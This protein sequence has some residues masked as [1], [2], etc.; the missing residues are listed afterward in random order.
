[1]KVAVVGGGLAGLCAAWRARELGTD[2]VLF[3]ASARLGGQVMTERVADCVLEHGAEGFVARST[4]VHAVCRLLGL[5]PE[6]ISQAKSRSLVYDGNSFREL[7]PGEAARRLGIQARTHWG[8]GLQSL[9]RGMGSLVESLADAIGEK[10]IRLSA[11]VVAIEPDS[12]GGWLVHLGKETVPA[13]G[14]VVALPGSAA[15][16]VLGGIPGRPAQ[17][18]G[19]L[20]TVSSLSVT[21][22]VADDQ[23][24][25]P[26]GASGMVMDDDSAPAGLRACSFASA[27][28]PGRAPPGRCVLRCF[29]RPPSGATAEHPWLDLVQ[30]Y[31]ARVIGLTGDPLVERV[32]SWPAALPR[33][34]T[35]HETQVAAV[36]DAL[37][38]HGR[39]V[40]AGASVARSGIDGAVRSGCAAGDAIAAR[41]PATTR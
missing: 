6:V 11:P 40:L 8:H 29:Y 4:S 31:L 16:N 1:M 26:P 39:V 15:G 5:E 24:A 7:P 33:Y 13:D 9:A 19:Q 28:F 18:L 30:Q 3:E 36:L 12:E 38:P 10:H 25:L 32:V 35:D 20:A 23:V 21:M 2:V 17:R 41:P 27:M 22:V 14:L 34:A 37:R